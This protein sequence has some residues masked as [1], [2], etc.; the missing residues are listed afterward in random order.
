MF[1]LFYL[2]G[3]RLKIL[4]IHAAEEGE[5]SLLNQYP[6]SPAMAGGVRLMAAIVRTLVGSR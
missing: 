6:L 1:A 5:G 2:E 3:T 4:L